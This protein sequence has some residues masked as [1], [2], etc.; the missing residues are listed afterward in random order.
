MHKGVVE[1][2]ISI[3]V[4]SSVSIVRGSLVLYS[5]ELAK[6][7]RD[8][9][10]HRSKCVSSHQSSTDPHLVDIPIEVESNPEKEKREEED[11]R[12]SHS[13]PHCQCQLDERKK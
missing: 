4:A 10:I 1:G 9:L 7:S 6:M 13:E 12:E 3:I 5:H 11:E 8:H 2:V